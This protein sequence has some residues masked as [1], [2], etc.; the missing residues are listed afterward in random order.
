MYYPLAPRTAIVLQSIDTA[1][2]LVERTYDA[3]SSDRAK[4]VY[5]TV[6]VI[7]VS[8]IAFAFGQTVKGL[9]WSAK[10]WYQLVFIPQLGD[11]YQQPVSLPAGE[12]V[13]AVVDQQPV[14]MPSAAAAIATK[15]TAVTATK[16][17]VG[18]LPAHTLNKNEM[19]W[20]I[21]QRTGR[22]VPGIWKLRR[23]ALEE[24]Y[25]AV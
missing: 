25:A 1:A 16:P 2:T 4:V 8:L 7:T 20:Q 24:I 6:A 13:D 14:V 15:P 11:L 17:V 21:Q 19:I 10:Q 22:K 18:K 23:E 5:V 12:V 3:F 9:R